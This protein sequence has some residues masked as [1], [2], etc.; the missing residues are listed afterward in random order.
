VLDVVPTSAPTA[1]T[2]PRKPRLEISFDMPFSLFRIVRV[3]V[4]FSLQKATFAG[5][6]IHRRESG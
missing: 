6:R 3:M 1:P 4:S 5:Q 2:R